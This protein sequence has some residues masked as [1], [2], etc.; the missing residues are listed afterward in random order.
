DDLVCSN[1]V[2]NDFNCRDIVL[3][4]VTAAQSIILAR[5]ETAGAALSSCTGLN[6]TDR[7]RNAARR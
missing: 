6:R 4:D 5:F 2:D 1:V 7:A 3:V